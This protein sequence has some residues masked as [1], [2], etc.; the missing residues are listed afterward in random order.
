MIMKGKDIEEGEGV[1][2]TRGLGALNGKRGGRGIK[3]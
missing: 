3:V 1:K 2:N